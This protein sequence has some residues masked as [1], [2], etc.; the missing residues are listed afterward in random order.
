[1]RYEELLFINGV[2]EHFF[3]SLFILYISKF[4]INIHGDSRANSFGLRNV[5]NIGY[6][7]PLKNALFFISLNKIYFIIITKKLAG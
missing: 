7:C 2:H 1:M 5:D 6:L 4:I 3:E